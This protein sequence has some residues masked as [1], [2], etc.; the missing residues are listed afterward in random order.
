MTEINIVGLP[1]QLNPPFVDRGRSS[2][3]PLRYAV[4][5][6]LGPLCIFAGYA[7]AF[8]DAA[9]SSLFAAAQKAA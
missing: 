7:N 2:L 3:W 1:G 8:L 6:N 5:C 4:S 9:Q